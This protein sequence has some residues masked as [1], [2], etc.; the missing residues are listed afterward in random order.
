MPLPKVV[1]FEDDDDFPLPFSVISHVFSFP[2]SG[3]LINRNSNW[4]PQVFDW[5]ASTVAKWAG[6]V[7]TWVVSPL[8]GSGLSSKVTLKVKSFRWLNKGHDELRTQTNA[9]F[10]WGNLGP[11]NW[12]YVCC[13]CLIFF[14]NW[15]PC[16]DPCSTQPKQKK[17]T[18]KAHDSL[19]SPPKIAPMARRV[20]VPHRHQPATCWRSHPKTLKWGAFYCTAWE[21]VMFIVAYWNPYITG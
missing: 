14:L 16:N 2:G 9:P 15:V 11:S 13:H 20:L 8:T 5:F 18:A 3:F 10:F 12:P 1:F 19:S 7:C 4:T 6:V 17:K 21:I